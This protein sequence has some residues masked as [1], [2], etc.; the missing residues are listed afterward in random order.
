[1]KR[2]SAVIHNVAMFLARKHRKRFG[3]GLALKYMRG[4]KLFWL[5]DWGTTILP[6][7]SM[8]NGV[9][10]SSLVLQCAIYF[11]LCI[12]PR[13][14]NPAFPIDWGNRLLSSVGLH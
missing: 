13:C 14:L 12:S 5:P 3:T 2:G 4:Q 9:S 11:F 10:I 1:M 7:V 6:M 8:P